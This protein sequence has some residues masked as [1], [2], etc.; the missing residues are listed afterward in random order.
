MLCYNKNCNALCFMTDYHLTFIRR[1]KLIM[2]II[3][4]TIETILKMEKKWNSDKWTKEQEKLMTMHNAL[5][6]RDHIERLYVKK[7]RKTRIRQH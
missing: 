7:R 4:I 2:I 3:I 5:H 6:P 1:L